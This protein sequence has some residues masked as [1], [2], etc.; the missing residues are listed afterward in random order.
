MEDRWLLDRG[1]GR[2][3]PFLVS[4]ASGL[5]ALMPFE[6]SRRD[7]RGLIASVAFERREASRRRV[8]SGLSAEVARL[9]GDG[10][11][12]D[13]RN[14]ATRRFGLYGSNS[15][16]LFKPFVSKVYS[17]RA[18]FF[19]AASSIGGNALPLFP[20]RRKMPLHAFAER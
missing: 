17:D 19:S 3:N 7:V 5:F 18:T 1:N 14:I 16:T 12:V 13:Q 15:P 9:E 11:R 10:L 4:N 6:S 20:A 8:G 2:S